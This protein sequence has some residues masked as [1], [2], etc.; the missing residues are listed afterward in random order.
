M[1]LADLLHTLL[2]AALLGGTALAVGGVVWALVVLQIWRGDRPRVD[3]TRCL[4]LDAAGA[5]LL[6]ASQAG[7]LA[8]KTAALSQA[9]GAN[10][11]PEFA[12]TL[13]FNAGS[14][15]LLLALGL[16]GAAGWLG[17]APG[18]WVRWLVVGALA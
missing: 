9:F 12:T 15:R 2:H 4:G 3:V 8:L 17:R 10:T 5:F 13:H 6:A 16:V 11:F 18:A 1:V 7:L 14:A